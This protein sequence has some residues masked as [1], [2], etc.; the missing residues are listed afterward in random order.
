MSY[1]TDYIAR[2][3]AWVDDEDLDDATV[4]EWIRDAEERMNNELRTVEQI[5]R[6]YATFDD[7]CALLPPDWQEHIYVRIKGGV[8]FDYITPHDYWALRQPPSTSAQPDPTGGEVYPWPGQKQLYTT[9][10][11]T[12]FVWPS[13]DP[14]AGIQVEIAYFRALIPL[15][16]EKDPVFDRYPSIYRACTLAAG[17]PFLIEDE[18]FGVFASLATAGIQKANDATRAG[19]WSGSP[20]PPRIRGFG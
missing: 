19:R 9:I 7:D 8:P 20:L 12:L 4:T 11:N 1:L 2:I 15:S 5:H 16:S 13:V 18:R 6:D 17:A 3:R 14:D 10:G